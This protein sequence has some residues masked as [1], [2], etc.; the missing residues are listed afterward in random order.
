MSVSCFSNVNLWL[1]Q[2]RTLPWIFF[3]ECSYFFHNLYL[4]SEPTNNHCFDTVAPGQLSKCNRRNTITTISTLIKGSS[5]K[6]NEKE[7][8]NVGDTELN[9]RPLSLFQSNC[10]HRNNEKEEQATCFNFLEMSLLL[11]E[12]VSRGLGL[13]ARGQIIGP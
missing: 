7:L 2:N 11:A 8:N 3:E 12:H 9:F 13:R 6:Q 10:I 5:L 1:Y 4:F